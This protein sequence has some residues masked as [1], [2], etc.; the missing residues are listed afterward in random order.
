MRNVGV[1][2]ALPHGASGARGLKEASR[3]ALR[4]LPLTSGPGYG[5]SMTGDQRKPDAPS[6]GGVDTEREASSKQS[7]EK[8]APSPGA[9]AA[10]PAGAVLPPGT[11]SETTLLGIAPPPGAPQVAQRDK[12]RVEPP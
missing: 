7:P 9:A 5:W 12:P 2:I 4:G 11:S 3:R 1:P 8:P 10:K 6:T